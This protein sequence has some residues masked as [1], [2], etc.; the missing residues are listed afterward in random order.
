MTT[1]PPDDREFALLIQ[2]AGKPQQLIARFLNMLLTYRYGLDII[3]ADNFA[4]AYAQV[5]QYGPR[6]RCAFVIQQKKR[7]SQ[8]R[9]VKTTSISNTGLVAASGVA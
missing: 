1:P 6:I 7:I 4:G 9:R 3:S 8:R 2:T 5:K